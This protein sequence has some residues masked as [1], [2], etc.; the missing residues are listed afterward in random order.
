MQM[1]NFSPFPQPTHKLLPDFIQVKCLQPIL[2]GAE[3]FSFAAAMWQHMNHTL[4]TS[5]KWPSSKLRCNAL[6]QNWCHQHSNK[7]A[8]DRSQLWQTTPG[9][10]LSKNVVPINE[11]SVSV[12]MPL[13]QRGYCCW[14]MDDA[15]NEICIHE[16][17]PKC[18]LMVTFSGCK[19][20]NFFN[21]VFVFWRT[22]KKLVIT[23]PHTHTHTNL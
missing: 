5:R 8:W 13:R 14:M 21:F 3:C 4:C 7:K 12:N 22:Q 16:K 2:Q 23:S 20:W 10:K 15:V 18:F 6:W 9:L 19:E 1:P 17:I 11:N